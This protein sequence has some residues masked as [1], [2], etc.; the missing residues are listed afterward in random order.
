MFKVQRMFFCGFAAAMLLILG[1]SNTSSVNAAIADAS[2]SMGGV[3]FG[4]FSYLT[5]QNECLY[6]LICTPLQDV[7]PTDAGYQVIA[8]DIWAASG[9]TD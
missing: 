4:A 7:H 6:S 1:V 5:P 2:Q 3:T 8:N 9:Y